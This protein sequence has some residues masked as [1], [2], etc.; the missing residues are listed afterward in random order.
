[1]WHL[2]CAFINLN[3]KRKTNLFYTVGTDSNFITFSNY[4]E[5]MT[6]N[7]LSTDTKLFPSAFICL[8]VADLT[9]ESRPG[10]IKFITQSYENKLAFLRDKCVEHDYNIE[11]KIKPLNWLLDILRS[12]NYNIEYTY[13]GQITEQDYNGV[14]AD[15]ICTIDSSA[16]KNIN[17]E[18]GA[19]VNALNEEY[20][21]PLDSLYGWSNSDIC[22]DEF[23]SL[24][25]ILDG[26][27]YYTYESFTKSISITKSHSTD[28][29]VFN[30]VIPLY[31]IVNTNY[32]TNSTLINET[33]EIDLTGDN[34]AT[35]LVPYGMWFADEA[36]ELPRTDYSPS[37]SLVLSSQFKPFPYSKS[38]VTEI[39]ESSKIDAYQTFS[40]ILVRQNA[41]MDKMNELSEQ[42]IQLSNR[43]ADIEGNLKSYGTSYNID[44]LH[45]EIEEL[46]RSLKTV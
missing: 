11:K 35:T 23:K 2:N 22:P 38:E 42:L 4:T 24:S 28:P 10:F 41:I 19:I 5:S 9:K 3:M 26:D 21:E 34:L 45:L 27:N 25:P 39:D 17:I 18:T 6:G 44:G 1:M 40:Q 31:D 37:W 30:V 36:I 20:D 43:V 14:Y 16:N 15:M 33:N 32:K 8:N 13:M 29:L 12:S 46:K 7:Y